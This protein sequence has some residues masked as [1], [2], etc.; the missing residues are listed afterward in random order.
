[1]HSVWFC[2]NVSR[3]NCV[4]YRHLLLF[5]HGACYLIIS[6]SFHHHGYGKRERGAI[7]EGISNGTIIVDTGSPMQVSA[8]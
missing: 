7:D 8:T 3:R 5:F 4:I 2:M 1:M 6:Y